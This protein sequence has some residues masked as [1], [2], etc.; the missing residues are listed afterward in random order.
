M[1]KLWWTKGV[2]ECWR[3]GR[4]GNMALKYERRTAVRL[5]FPKAPETSNSELTNSK[6]ET[7]NAEKPE[8][9]DFIVFRVSS[10]SYE[11]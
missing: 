6:P 7:H 11:N 2:M 8:I 10:K 4:L 5:N 9:F 1:L 3:K